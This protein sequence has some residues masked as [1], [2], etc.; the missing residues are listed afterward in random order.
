MPMAEIAPIRPLDEAAALEWLRS[1]PGGR[2]NL[3]AAEL[4][5]RWGSYRQRTGQRLKAWTKAGL[6]TRRGNTGA[7]AEGA[8][9][10]ATKTV[11]SNVTRAV[12]RPARVTSRAPVSPLQTGIDVAAYTAAIVLAGAAAW[13]SIK[14]M[15]VL[16][17][18][19]PLFVIAMAVVMEGLLHVDLVRD[20]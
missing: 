16:F 9:V 8:P 11:T 3:P 19:A 18:G 2:I 5:R 6:V 20:S 10:A 12:T 14:G 13:F 7:I 15:A 1:Q 17:P 4:G